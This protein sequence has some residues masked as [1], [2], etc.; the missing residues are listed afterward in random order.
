MLRVNAKT[1]NGT[2]VT[3]SLNFPSPSQIIEA[4]KI[5]VASGSGV[6]FNSHIISTMIS[7]GDQKY[8]ADSEV[9]TGLCKDVVVSRLIGGAEITFPDDVK[10]EPGSDTPKPDTAS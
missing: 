2:V 1:H 5:Q 3:V 10:P 4:E 9:F 6:A 8:L 7:A